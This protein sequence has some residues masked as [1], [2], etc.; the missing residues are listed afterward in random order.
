LKLLSLVHHLSSWQ[1]RNQDTTNALEAIETTKK[2]IN[3][4]SR[5]YNIFCKIMKSPSDKRTILSSDPQK[6][7]KKIMFADEARKEPCQV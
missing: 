5:D 7:Q 6:Q 3:T 2:W 4:M 1:R